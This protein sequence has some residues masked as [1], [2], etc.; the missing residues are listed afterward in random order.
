V[1]EDTEQ[2]DEK[3][4][5]SLENVSPTAAFL[6][7]LPLQSSIA[8]LTVAGRRVEWQQVDEGAIGP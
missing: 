7:N 1:S 6:L 3:C 8:A 4:K 2:V 5:G